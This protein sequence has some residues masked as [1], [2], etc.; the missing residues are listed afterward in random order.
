VPLTALQVKKAAPRPAEYE[1]SDGEGLSLRVRPCGSKSW[2][3]RFR[4]DGKQSH[5]SLG[6]AERVSLAEARQL[7]ADGRK[8]VAQGKHPGAERKSK[9]AQASA[10]RASTFKALALEWHS[11]KCAR[12]SVGYA[13]DVLEGFEKDI[14]PHLGTQ[15][16]VAIKPMEWLGVFRR[17]ESRGALEKLRKVRQRCGEVYRFAIATGRAEYNPI[18]DIGG[19]LQAPEAEHYPFLNVTELPALLAALQ[20]CPGHDVVK[21]AARLLMLTGVRTAELRGAP[22]SEFDFDAELWSIPAVRMKKRRPHL[23]PL[24]RQALEVLRELRTITGGYTLAFPGRNDPAKPMSE[25]AINQLLKRAGYDGKATGHG[26]RHTQSTSL[27]EQGYASEWIE[28]QLAHVDKNTIRGTYN[29]AQ[30]LDGRRQML[31]W[32]ADSID[33]LCTGKNVLLFK[34]AIQA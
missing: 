25:A 24:S 32:Y 8:L 15:P 29:H 30:Y 21:L 1:L 12:W 3:L 7:A 31:Q 19:A 28:T 17:I 4:L 33:A 14:F 10:S 11:H 18:A 6:T 13:T 27:H 16:L 20:V 5:I 2:R 22:W 23:V 26:F 34:R 9:R